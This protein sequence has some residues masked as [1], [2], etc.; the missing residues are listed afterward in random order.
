MLVTLTHPS[1]HSQLRRWLHHW[2]KVVKFNHLWG[3]EQILSHTALSFLFSEK[4]SKEV[5]EL[6]Y[7]YQ[8][9]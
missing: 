6:I 2:G 1:M 5:D 8:K 7:L 3:K 9:P 4:N